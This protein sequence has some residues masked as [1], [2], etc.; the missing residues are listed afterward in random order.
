MNILPSH[1]SLFI[2]LHASHCCCPREEGNIKWPITAAATVN[3]TTHFSSQRSRRPESVRF[4]EGKCG[5]RFWAIWRLHTVICCASSHEHFCPKSYLCSNIN[6]KVCDTLLCFLK[7]HYLFI[8]NC[9]VFYLS[10]FQVCK[11]KSSTLQSLQLNF[12][13][14]WNI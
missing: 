13:F 7:N 3:L 9:Y 4:D 11:G 2:C 5:G 14:R 10:S 8:L 6:F 12:I 1:K